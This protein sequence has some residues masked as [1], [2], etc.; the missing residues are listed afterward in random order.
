M[1][2]LAAFQ[3][4]YA[5]ISVNPWSGFSLGGSQPPQPTGQTR[6]RMLLGLMEIHDAWK[7]Q[8]DTLGEPYYL[9]IWLY[10]PRFVRSQVVCAIRESIDFYGM[11][12]HQP[13]QAK[14]PPPF[15]RLTKPL[16]AFRWSHALDE[17]HIDN[18]DLLH[19]REHGPHEA[20][21]AEKRW[22]DGLRKKN[23]RTTTFETPFGS[24]TESYAFK[25]GSVWLG[26]KK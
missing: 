3:R 5:K 22:L 4:D 17:D 14:S 11:T 2:R 10:E 7:R 24:A 8:L 6:A 12:F 19:L 1:E 15:P 13:D 16:A 20:C 23:H 9:R 21:I 25:R 18:G 26:E